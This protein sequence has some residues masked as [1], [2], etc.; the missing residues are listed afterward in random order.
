MGA[1]ADTNELRKPIFRETLSVFQSSLPQ[2]L[3]FLLLNDSLVPWAFRSTHLSQFR[4]RG[5]K[6]REETAENALSQLRANSTNSP[7]GTKKESVK[8]YQETKHRQ[9]GEEEEE[10]PSPVGFCLF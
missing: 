7:P 10:S 6:P 5:E 9:E 3:H 8:R 2:F 4:V 1:M